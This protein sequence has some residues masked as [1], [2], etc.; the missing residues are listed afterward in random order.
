MLS[1]GYQD[2]V[3]GMFDTFSF[4]NQFI[5]NFE[6]PCLRHKMKEMTGSGIF[7]ANAKEK[8]SDSDVAPTPNSQ[9]RLCMYQVCAY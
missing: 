2:L 4:K 7:V 9:T 3:C 6:K 5:I 1:F 8:T